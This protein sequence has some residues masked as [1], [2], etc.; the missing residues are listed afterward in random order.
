MDNSAKDIGV[1]NVSKLV[2]FNNVMSEKCNWNLLQFHYHEVYE[3]L[4]CLEAEDVVCFAEDRVYE[5]KRGSVFLFPPYIMHRTT[6]TQNSQYHRYVIYF[7]TSDLIDFSYYSKSLLSFFEKGFMHLE[8]NEKEIKDIVNIV[9][10]NIFGK[11][12]KFMPE[13]KNSMR[14]FRLILYLSEISSSNEDLQITAYNEINDVL[15]YIQKNIKDSEMTLSS[16]SKHFYRSTTSI[17]E[18]FKKYMHSTVKEY[19]I[20][21]RINLAQEYLRKDYSVSA[22][23]DMVGFNNYSHFIRTFKNIVGISPKQYSKKMQK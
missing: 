5:M 8:L 20:S 7:N 14:L 21:K 4:I 3:M 22:V 12:S 11:D 18:L 10:D 23:C 13:I 15:D 16:I 6:T 9:D 19:I 17:N 2:F 1:S